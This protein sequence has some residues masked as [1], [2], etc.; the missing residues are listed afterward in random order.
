MSLLQTSTTSLQGSMLSQLTSNSTH[1]PGNTTWSLLQS[2]PPWTCT[3][4]RDALHSS[5]TVPLF[6]SILSI[7]LPGKTLPC[8]HIV[9]SGKHPH[10]GIR[11]SPC[12]TRTESAPDWAYALGPSQNSPLSGFP[13]PTITTHKYPGFFLNLSHQCL[14]ACPSHT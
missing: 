10:I 2:H 13:V 14:R 11:N 3:R 6:L 8:E 1:S 9:R 5:L 12:P 7:L 4:T